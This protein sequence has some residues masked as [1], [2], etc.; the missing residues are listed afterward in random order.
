M[1]DFFGARA[2]M[3]LPSLPNSVMYCER[4]VE[5][6][7]PFTQHYTKHSPGETF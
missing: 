2:W 6:R 7:D 3:Q 4:E 1:S 5:T